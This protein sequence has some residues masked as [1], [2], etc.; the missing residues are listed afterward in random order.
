M[1]ALAG[2]RGEPL[3]SRRVGDLD[4]PAL[5]LEL[6]VHEA[7]AVHRLDRC[8]DRLLVAVESSGE[9]AQ[10]VTVGWRRPDL[11]RLPALVAQV[12]VEASSAQIQTGV[13]H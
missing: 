1:V 10:P 11:D 8:L 2:E 6:I 4:L 9:A 12:E 13:Q 7:G 5:Q 3:H